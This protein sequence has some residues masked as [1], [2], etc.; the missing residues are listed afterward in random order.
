FCKD[1]ITWRVLRHP[2]ALPP[3]GAIMINNR[4]A[5]VSKG[6][7][8]GN[9]NQ[10]VTAH[11][12][13][14]QFKLVGSLFKSPH[15]RLSL[16]NASHTCLADFGLLITASDATNGYVFEL[17]STER[18]APMDEPRTLVICEVLAGRVPSSRYR[19]YAVVAKTHKGERPGRPEGAEE[20]WFTDDAWNIMERC[21]KSIPGDR[22][23]AMYSGE[24]ES[25]L[26]PSRRAPGSLTP[27][28]SI[29]KS[30]AG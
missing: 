22:P 15:L 17:A 7:K 28:S 14:T 27:F 26:C 1:V 18:N 24:W 9:I 8:N 19:G 13:A 3:L 12:D 25:Q 20:T 5:M 23:V 6:M 30:S 2:N 21:W 16:T 11:L 29:T 10:Y 4:F